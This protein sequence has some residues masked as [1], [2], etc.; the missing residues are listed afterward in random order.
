MT[1]KVKEKVEEKKEE[2]KVEESKREIVTPGEVIVSGE[3]YLPGDGTRKEGKDIIA[4]RYGLADMSGRLIKLI[5]LAGGYIPRYGNTVIGRI[6]DVTFNGWIVDIDAPYNAFLQLSE[7]P[8]FINKNELAEYY[9]IGEVIACKI[10]SVKRKAIDLTLRSKGLGKLEGGVIMKINSN[11][12]PRIIGKEGS[13][14]KLIKQSTN[15]EIIVGQNGL[16]WI[17][18]NTIEDERKAKDVIL[19]VASKSYIKGLTEKVK[20]FLE[21]GKK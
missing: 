16:I 14:I 6:T 11:K 2:E 19:F 17:K 15:S 3:D 21:G 4:S 1:P 12:V 18:A 20:E 10:L 13:M 9:D 5:P 7:V 8:M